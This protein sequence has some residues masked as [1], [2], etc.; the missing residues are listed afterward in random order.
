MRQLILRNANETQIDICVNFIKSFGKYA[1]TELSF[2]NGEP[3][4]EEIESKCTLILAKTGH[5]TGEAQHISV[6]SHNLRHRTFTTFTTKA[7]Q[8]FVFASG[9]RV[10]ERVIIDFSGMTE[11][12]YTWS[13]ALVFSDIIEIPTRYTKTIKNVAGDTASLT[14]FGQPNFKIN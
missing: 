7:T 4:L 10:F 3:K 5:Q 8:G 14:I 11:R 1:T 9:C 13:V 2:D 12:E 6:S